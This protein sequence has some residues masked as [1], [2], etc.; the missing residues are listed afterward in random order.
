[1]MWLILLMLPPPQFI[2]L[3]FIYIVFFVL[4]FYLSY[5]NNM[6]ESPFYPNGCSQP[7]TFV[8]YLEPVL[9]SYS[10]TY[11][12]IITLSCFPCGPLSSL[13]RRMSFPR[14][15]SFSSGLGFGG[16]F[17][18]SSHCSFVLM[19]YPVSSGGRSGTGSYMFS[20]DIPAVFS[21]L[22]ANGYVIQTDYTSMMNRSRVVLGTGFEGVGF[23]S[24]G[25]K[26]M[27]CFVSYSG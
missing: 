5:N 13:V 1:M 18:R 8:M 26:R 22:I 17:N 6:E 15:S 11:M 25:N 12:N 4:L 23:D 3:V 10:Q 16:G 14:L 24:N 7:S 2:I 27:I 21:Y 9:D 19:R 20:E